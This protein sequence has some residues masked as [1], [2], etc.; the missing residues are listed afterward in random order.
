M[1]RRE[2]GEEKCYNCHQK[3]DMGVPFVVSDGNAIMIHKSHVMQNTMVEILHYSSPGIGDYTNWII[4]T[5]AN[6]NMIGV[7][8]FPNGCTQDPIY[9]YTTHLLENISTSLQSVRLDQIKCAMKQHIATCQNL[10]MD[11]KNNMFLNKYNI[12]FGGDFNLE[13][14]ETLLQDFLTS[15]LFTDV[16]LETDHSMQPNQTGIT[17]AADIHSTLYNPCI[18]GANQFPDQSNCPSKNT[19]IDYIF[20]TGTL[21]KSKEATIVMQTPI[22]NAWM[23]DHFGVFASFDSTHNTVTNSINISIDESSMISIPSYFLQLPSDINDNNFQVSTKGLTVQNTGS[24]SLYI[25]IF[26]SG[27][28]FCSNNIVLSSQAFASFWFI[29]EGPYTIVYSTDGQKTHTEIPF[30]FK[31]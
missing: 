21:L 10:C 27:P 29:L 8:I 12:I 24:I 26:G 28:V 15:N 31:N 9:I 2:L 22:Q 1:S 14:T 6:C 17:F 18:Y 20:Y 30:H 3:L 7:E 13:P 25:E 16:W 23:S 19:R 5:G 11:E 4:S